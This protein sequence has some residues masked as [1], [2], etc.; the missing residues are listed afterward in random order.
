MDDLRTATP[1]I[2]VL[3]HRSPTPKRV[4]L[5]RVPIVVGRRLRRRRCAVEGT[6]HGLDGIGRVARLLTTARLTTRGASVGSSKPIATN[7]DL[8][9]SCARLVG[10]E[11]EV[12]LA[13]PGPGIGDGATVVLRGRRRAAGH[14]RTRRRGPRP[15]RV[16]RFSAR[17]L[18]TVSTPC[19]SRPGLTVP[20]GCRLLVQGG[21]PTGAPVGRGSAEVPSSRC[22][23]AGLS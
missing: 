8:V 21:R 14:P 1:L 19:G 17:P 9:N 5:H 23:I 22:R 20:L 10:E 7:V 3:V 15:A 12:L 2:P 4:R 11:V 13:D 16:V 18:P 6:L